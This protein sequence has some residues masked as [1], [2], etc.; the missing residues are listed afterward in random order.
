MASHVDPIRFGE[1]YLF[2]AIFARSLLSTASGRTSIEQYSSGLIDEHL[3]HFCNANLF[4]WRLGRRQG[5][6]K[7][8]YF[9]LAGY[10]GTIGLYFATLPSYEISLIIHALWGVT[11]TLLFWSSIVRVTRHWAPQTSKVKLLVF[12]KLEEAS[13]MSLCLFRY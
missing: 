4:S 12:C 10:H 1:L 5:N 8:S 7:I 3:R 11:T 9:N 2:A 6:T 13:V